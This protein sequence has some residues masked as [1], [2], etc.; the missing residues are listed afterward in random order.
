[1]AKIYI[2]YS[3][4]DNDIALKL[5]NALK[6]LGHE[7]LIDTQELTPGIDWRKK[8][9]DALKSAD[10]IITLITENSLSS[11]FVMSEIG[12]ARTY[13]DIDNG[14]FFIPVIFGKLEIPLVLQDIQCL[15]A[16]INSIKDTAHKINQAITSLYFRQKAEQEKQAKQIEKIETNASKYVEDAMT[17]LRFRESRNKLI[18]NVWYS[19]GFISLLAGVIFGAYGITEFLSVE[20]ITVDVQWTIVVILTIKT[21]VI[22]GLLI[23]CSKYSFTL[24]KSYINEA[25]KNA[26]RSH[27][28]SF[29]KFYLDAYG[30]TAKWEDLKE[31]FQYWNINN[32]SSFSKLDTNQYDPKFVE[33]VVELSKIISSK[34]DKK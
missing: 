22:I 31:A 6:D 15:F 20:K 18:G 24:G 11:Q 13:L 1:M 5:T 21:A 29:G 8:I 30:S 27:A 28:I 12:A 19:L 4:K 25:L 32:E 3:T 17:R 9:T 16:D 34:S 14:K 2:S 26:D 7:I 10:G 33:L 23:T